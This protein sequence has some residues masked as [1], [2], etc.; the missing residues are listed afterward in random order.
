M[1]SKLTRMAKPEPP[2]GWPWEEEWSRHGLSL[3]RLR[4]VM[5]SL[6]TDPRCKI[7]YAPFAGP[8]KHLVRPFG[9]RQSRKNPRL[10][11]V[12]FEDAPD[13]GMEMDGGVLFADVRGYTTLSETVPPTGLAMLLNRFYRAA[14]DALIRH[15]AVIDKLVG[16]EVMAIFLPPIVGGET[17]EQ[18]V[19]AADELLRAVGFGTPEGPWL[20]VGVGLDFGRVFAGNVGSGSQVR[21]FTALGDAV[22]TAARLQGAAGPGQIV[23]SERVY[24]AVAERYAGAESVSLEL[25]GKSAPVAARVVDLSGSAEVPDQE[26]PTWAEHVVGRVS[27]DV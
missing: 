26:W 1:G 19:G 15:D 2:E 14:T 5:R 13:G 12:C 3:R 23:M 24:E 22:N 21:D 25:K 16:D 18:M 11:S 4:P 20:P 17:R 10:C 7:C 27:H 9:Y 6:P 8:G